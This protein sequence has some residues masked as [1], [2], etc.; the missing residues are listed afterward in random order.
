[1]QTTPYATDSALITGLKSSAHSA[2]MSCTT[3][4][5]DAELMRHQQTVIAALA[6]MQDRLLVLT[7]E[8]AR[9]PL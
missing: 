8:A 5:R 2:F 3:I 1:M 6:A 4:D 7:A 9:K